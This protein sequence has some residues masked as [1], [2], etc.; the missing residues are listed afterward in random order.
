MKLRHLWILVFCAGCKAPAGTQQSPSVNNSGKANVRTVKLYKPGDQTS[1]PA[2]SLGSSEGLELHFDDMDADIK[3]YYYSFQLCN[4]DW[5]PSVLHPYEFIKGFQTVRI[6]NYRNS[7]ISSTRY[8]HYQTTVPDRT[9]YPTKSGNYLLKVFLN[10]DTNQ[11]VF[12]KRFIVVDNKASI[13]A[14]VQQPFNAQFY[15]SHQ[16]LQIA[17]T[18]DNRIQV[19]SPQDIRVVILQNNNWRTAVQTDRPTIYRG[20]YYEYSDEAFTAIPA[21]KEWRWIDLRS[22]RL[23][24]DRMESIDTRKDTTHVY[25]KLDGSRNGQLY[26]YY[27]DLNGRYTVE[28]MENVNPFWQGD[29]G[30]VH[31][32]YVPP[33]NRA[34]EGRD[35]HVFGEL[36][37]YATGDAGRMD[38]NETRGVYEKTLFLKQGFY[39]YMYVTTPQGGGGFPDFSSTEGNNPTTEN[40]YTVLVYFRPFG[41]RAD[42]LI[43]MT[44]LSS[45]FG[46]R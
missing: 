42:E 11:L 28:T 15:R 20:N 10:N 31:F 27:R 33:G 45:N 22:L 40:E 30:L 43:G 5:T 6:S 23:R 35:V 29:Y 44:Q 39:N 41:A 3:N 19:F 34:F 13:A 1:F 36:T 21:G 25:V 37:D 32:T 17:I 9:S 26:V 14:Q 4:A 7:S 38:F 18:T 12:A 46:I 8:T 24:S 16:K 2:I